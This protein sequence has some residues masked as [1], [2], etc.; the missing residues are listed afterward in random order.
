MHVI[1]LF[2]MPDNHKLK[3]ILASENR[4]FLVKSKIFVSRIFFI[5]FNFIV[6]FIRKLK[7]LK[8]FKINRWNKKKKNMAFRHTTDRKVRKR[9]ISP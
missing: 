2:E 8:Y 9:N 3:H 1:K 4:I 6:N 5:L 7:L